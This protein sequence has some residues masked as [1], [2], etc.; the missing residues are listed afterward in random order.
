MSCFRT[1]TLSEGLAL[2]EKALEVESP[3][4]TQKSVSLSPG[5]DG[6]E[7]EG[8]D[9]VVVLFELSGSKSRSSP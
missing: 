5:D 6:G 1:C 4:M 7:V 3:S 2:I 8:G 9:G